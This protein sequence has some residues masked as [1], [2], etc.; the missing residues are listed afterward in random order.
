MREI[1]TV[2]TNI[3]TRDRKDI[4]KSLTGFYHQLG[5]HF[6]LLS[7]SNFL[8]IYFIF[9]SSIGT[10]VTSLRFS[11]H[12]LSNSLVH[13]LHHLVCIYIYTLNEIADLQTPLEH[14][15]KTL[16]SYFWIKPSSFPH[17]ILCRK[18]ITSILV[19]TTKQR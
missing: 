8:F 7:F 12:F 19:I 1:Q 2:I 15:D 6:L 5:N 9:L 4:Y 3:L 14:F 10:P 16:W 13:F 11:S 17:L 18:L